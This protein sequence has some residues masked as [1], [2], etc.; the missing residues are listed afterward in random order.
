MPFNFDANSVRK[1]IQHERIRLEDL[2][3][4]NIKPKKIEDDK[5][6]HWFITGS[7]KLEGETVDLEIASLSGKLFIK[8][9]EDI[10]ILSPK[11]AVLSDELF[12]RIQMTLNEKKEE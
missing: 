7:I 4:V 12:D 5:G 3:S 2:E 11:N 1:L 9:P 6:G 10:V 8:D